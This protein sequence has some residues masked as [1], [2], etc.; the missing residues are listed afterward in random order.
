M[1]TEAGWKSDVNSQR[2][3]K[4]PISTFIVSMGMV[5]LLLGCGLLSGEQK[6]AERDGE[7][8][9]VTQTVPEPHPAEP[10]G[11]VSASP[12]APALL[13]RKVS[14]APIFSWA[15]ATSLET[16]ILA[17]PVIARVRL[18][19]VSSTT[20]L[21]D[22]YRGMKYITLLEFNFSVLEYL[23]GNGDDDIVAVWASVRSLF[24]TQQEAEDALSAV[25]SARD[26]RWDAHDA[27]VFLQH[28]KP[29][30]PSTQ[31]AGRFY[32][33]GHSL[34]LG[35]LDDD[36]SLASR[37]NKLWL[38][39]EAAVGASSQPSGDQQPFLT[40]MPPAAGAAPTI[41]LGELKTQIAAVAA[42]LD[43]GDGSEEYREC[44]RRI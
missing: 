37:A 16:R 4:M 7:V 6:S 19:S 15:G 25:A 26:A 33:S 39:A 42:K 8:P 1:S 3:A 31:Q 17:S 2:I 22:T 27:I 20:E 10:D 24:D 13:N 14:V 5:L 38:P 36:Y 23:K 28:S 43:A 34:V 29:N 11:E 41:T 40:D 35:I 44:V 21:G 30:I 32:L 18:D 9:A 12:T